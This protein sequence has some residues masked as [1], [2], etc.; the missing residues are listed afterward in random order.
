MFGTGFPFVDGSATPFGADIVLGGDLLGEH[1]VLLGAVAKNREAASVA[2]GDGEPDHGGGWLFPFRLIAG[3]DR[4]RRLFPCHHRRL[5]GDVVR[6]AQARVH[7]LPGKGRRQVGGVAC[8]PDP[9]LAEA[10]GPGVPQA[11]ARTASLLRDD[12][13]ALSAI[14]ADALAAAEEGHEPGQGLDRQVLAGCPPAVRRRALRAAVLAEGVPPGA[15]KAEHLLAMDRVVVSGSGLVRLPGGVE[16]G[17]RCGRL[18][19][20]ATGG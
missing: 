4:R 16:A 17:V 9:A 3:Q 20:H 8:Q 2:H 12:E 7:A 15:L 1:A 13:E 11:L 10:L 6:V 5:P 19:L 18:V 14:A